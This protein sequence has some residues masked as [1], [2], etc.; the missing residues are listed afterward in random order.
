MT[1]ARATL[2]PRCDALPIPRPIACH[3]IGR[4]DYI[5]RGL[6]P[7]RGVVPPT[8]PGASVDPRF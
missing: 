8:P 6:S 2:T 1:A 3:D 5:P 4:V 7:D